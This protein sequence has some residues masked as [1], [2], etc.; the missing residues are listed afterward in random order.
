MKKKKPERLQYSL[1]SEY[2]KIWRE[3]GLQVDFVYGTT[4]FVPADLAILHVNLS[5]VP[6]KYIAFASQYPKA[7]N[8]TIKDIRK[9]TFS[10][11]RL[12]PG[13]VYE[14]AVIVKTNLNYAGIPERRCRSLG[15]RFID[16][17]SSADMV[18]HKKIT[19][20]MDYKIYEK[21][22]QVPQAY[23][24]NP[25]MIVEK[26]IPEREGDYYCIRT[27]LFCGKRMTFSYLKS[28]APIIRARSKVQFEK[29][30]PEP[31]V[32]ELINRFHFDFGKFD[33]VI[34]QGKAFIFDI[35]K[36]PGNRR[37]WIL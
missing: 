13:D 15:R 26:F 14:G 21:L 8:K 1:I 2:A 37:H 33:Y 7:L 4:K 31:Q 25:E 22:Q 6:D 12:N 34:H 19:H 11:L 29:S 10:S 24:D 17:I 23:F 27:C 30:V 5:I 18:Y 16:F 20:P 3:D 35:N 32:I 9:S 36:T 28:K